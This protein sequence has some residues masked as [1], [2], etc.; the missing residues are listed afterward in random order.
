M[1]DLTQTITQGQIAFA[2]AI[3]AIAV[4][5]FVFAKKPTRSKK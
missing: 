2:L 1:I 4:V 5:Y 3:V